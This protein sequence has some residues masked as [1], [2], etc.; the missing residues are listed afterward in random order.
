MAY[1][2]AAIVGALSIVLLVRLVLEWR[3]YSRGGHIISRRQ[4]M[5][6]VASAIVLVLLLIMVGVGIRLPLT[7]AEA[8]FAYWAVALVLALAA[9]VMA[10]VDLTLLRRIFGRRRAESYRRLSSYLRA[11]DRRREGRVGPE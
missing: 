5:L 11:V 3:R 2:F 10:I 9:I 4:M 7:T 8:A 6:R 1:W